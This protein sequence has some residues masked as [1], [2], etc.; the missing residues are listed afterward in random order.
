MYLHSFSKVAN[1]QLM[2][3]KIDKN[4][5]SYKKNYH[6]NDNNETFDKYYVYASSDERFCSFLRKKSK[7]MVLKY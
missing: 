7:K 5:K 6:F 1:I 2:M 4:L 3:I